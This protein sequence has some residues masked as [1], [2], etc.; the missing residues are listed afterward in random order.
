MR[1]GPRVHGSLTRFPPRSVNRRWTDWSPL[2]SLARASYDT[3][4]PKV[5]VLAAHPLRSEC[6]RILHLPAAA[7]NST[8]AEP[9][10]PLLDLPYA[11]SSAAFVDEFDTGVLECP[12]PCRGFSSMKPTSAAAS[13]R[14]ASGSLM[15]SSA[16][17]GG[18][19]SHW[20]PCILRRRLDGKSTRRGGDCDSGATRQHCRFRR[21]LQDVAGQWIDAGLALP[22]LQCP[23]PSSPGWVRFAK[24][25]LRVHY[26]FLF[27]FNR[28]EAFFSTRDLV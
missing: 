1:Y 27:V 11:R 16:K 5:P 18:L 13:R 10:S 14:H 26:L 12:S 8:V 24:A 2:G 9:L 23:H 28:T 22:D 6:G 7:I 15:R 3:R 21:N 20:S 17:I 25:G 4:G 19:G